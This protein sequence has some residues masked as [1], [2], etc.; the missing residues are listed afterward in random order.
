MKQIKIIITLLLLSIKLISQEIPNNFK[1]GNYM[2]FFNNDSIRIYYNCIGSIVDTN[3]ADFIRVGEIDS[4]YS[5]VTGAFV[6]YYFNGEIA[7]KGSMHNNELDGLG[8]YYYPD[9][10][11]KETGNYSNGI[12][13]GEWKYY[14][15]NG[16]PE[17]TLYFIE[18]SPLIM[19]CFTK[20]GKPKITNGV[21]TYKGFYCSNN[22]CEPYRISGKV[23]N[24]KMTGKWS[25]Y[26]LSNQLIGNEY[27]ENGEFVKGSS[28]NYEYSNNRLIFIQGYVPNE[29]F[30]I[31]E[32]RF[33]CPGN[34][35]TSFIEYKGEG[36]Y[37]K[38]YP[39]LAE[40]LKLL[41]QNQIKDQ[42]ILV[43]I[44][45]NE[46]DSIN[47]IKIFSSKNDNLIKQSLESIILK[48]SNF[49]E[50]GKINSTKVQSDFLFTII[51]NGNSVVIPAMIL[52][53]KQIKWLK[54]EK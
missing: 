29:N 33:G 50:T 14:H 2:E 16:K 6:D 49:W 42:W 8:T 37:D 19:N 31:Y 28:L 12:R 41:L 20:R 1:V 40:E 26:T 54:N 21:G 38:F 47:M 9:G 17:K 44:S 13:T 10:I 5:N 25:Y 30:F 3:C 24:G 46:N 34:Y 23:L 11:I 36:I 45:I 52:H 39:E 48:D 7:F 43:H 4:L 53:D 51:I 35:G 27:Y 18:G 22:N 15:Y 32:N